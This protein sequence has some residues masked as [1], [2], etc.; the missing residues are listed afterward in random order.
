MLNLPDFVDVITV[1][2]QLA[3]VL[4]ALRLITVTGG[5][6]AW[7]LV[8]IFISLITVNHIFALYG[9][10]CGPAAPNYHCNYTISPRPSFC[11]LE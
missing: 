7:V 5:S 3:S 4:F 6:I 8:S 10:F 11:C 1:A 2:V 9:F